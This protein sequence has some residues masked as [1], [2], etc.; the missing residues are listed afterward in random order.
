M[1]EIKLVAFVS[2]HPGKANKLALRYGIT[3]ANIY[4]YQ[5]YDSIRDNSE[6]DII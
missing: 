1:R 3:P 4:N 5:N 2:G 6:V